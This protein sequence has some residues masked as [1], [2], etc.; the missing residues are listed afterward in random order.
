MKR[1]IDAVGRSVRHRRLKSRMTQEELSDRAGIHYT[2]LG[3][4]ERG[5]RVPS[6]HTL[7]R[8]AQALSIPLSALLKDVDGSGA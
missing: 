1:L 3:H 2:F 5:T 4:I 6:L 7:L 8:I